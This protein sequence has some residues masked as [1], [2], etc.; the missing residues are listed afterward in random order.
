MPTSSCRSPCMWQR[1]SGSRYRSGKRRISSSITKR[2]SNSSGS[3]SGLIAFAVALASTNCRRA[4]LPR[5]FLATRS[6]TPCSQF[7]SKLRSRSEPSFLHE[8]QKREL[9]CILCGML[10]AHI[11]GGKLPV[12]SDHADGSKPG[13][14]PR[15]SR[16]VQ[17]SRSDELAI[18]P[19]TH[20]APFVKSLKSPNCWPGNSHGRSP[21]RVAQ[22]K[23]LTLYCRRDRKFFHYFIRS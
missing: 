3:F 13:R 12:P 8:D 4:S 9:E 6:A 11:P 21:L 14:P 18:S 16:H 7:V 5:A 20:R 23:V 10:V 15:C 2:S 17:G 22:R 1:T 19:A